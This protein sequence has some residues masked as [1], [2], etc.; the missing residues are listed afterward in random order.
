MLDA[1]LG[2]GGQQGAKFQSGTNIGFDTTPGNFTYG[3]NIPNMSGGTLGLVKLGTNTL[4]L[5]GS[6]SYTG[7]TTINAGMLQLG[8]V[9]GIGSV[10]G[11]ILDNGTLGFGNSAVQSFTGAISGSGGLVMN[12]LATLT[13]Q[14][15]CN[16]TGPTLVLA[17]PAACKWAPASP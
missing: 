15:A 16:Y 10:Q 3:S 13:L 12:G 9:A 4:T 7:G 8:S 6:S 17:P 14:G 11:N 2:I 1:P 5:T